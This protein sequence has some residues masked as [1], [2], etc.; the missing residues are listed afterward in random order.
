MK[1]NVIRE[2]CQNYI[3]ISDQEDNEQT[4]KYHTISRKQKHKIFLYQS[5]LDCFIL[6]IVMSFLEMLK[7]FHLMICEKLMILA[8]VNILFNLKLNPV[9]PAL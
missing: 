3:D 7:L 1:E 4:T 2:D 5:Y 8:M 9:V 6:L